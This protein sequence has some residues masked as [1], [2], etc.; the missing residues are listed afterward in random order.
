MRTQAFTTGFRKPEPYAGALT[1][2]FISAVGSVGVVFL[3]FLLTVAIAAIMYAKGETRSRSGNPPRRSVS[4][5]VVV[6]KRY[7]LLSQAVRGVALGVVVT[8]LIQSATGGIG[9]AIAGV[10]YDRLSAH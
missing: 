7:G 3:Q 9:L 4:Q 8:A 5:V 1:Q 6:S 10:P 2:W